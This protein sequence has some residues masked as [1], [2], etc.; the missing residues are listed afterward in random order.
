MTS[1]FRFKFKSV[2]KA[3]RLLVHS[4]LT[5]PHVAKWFYGQ[6]LKNTFKYLDEF[7]HGSSLLQYWL[8]Y[9]KTHPF[10][11]LMTSS[12]CKPNDELT[13]WCSEEGDAIT[14]DMLIGDTHY[15]GKGFSHILIQEFLFSQFPQVAEVL[16]DPD[17]TNSHAI[18]IYKKA[19]FTILGEFI[20]SHSPNPHYM[21]RL[22]MKELRDCK[23][24]TFTV[25]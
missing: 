17:I 7:L 6:G 4:W 16:I 2:D 1:P 9:D 10:A 12:V 20:P 13:G 21:M 25:L 5:Q 8:A 11:L 19:G 22:N 24:I 15:L 3:H 18:H 14:R 23:K